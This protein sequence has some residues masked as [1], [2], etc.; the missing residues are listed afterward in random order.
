MFYSG[1]SEPAY[2][3]NKDGYVSVLEA[4]IA[5]A[6][7]TTKLSPQQHPVIADP[8]QSTWIRDLIL[9]NDLRPFN[10]IQVVETNAP[11]NSGSVSVD[12]QD[13]SKPFYFTQD[14]LKNGSD[15]QPAFVQP[16]GNG[17]GT[18]RF[19]DYPTR[20]P[21]VGQEVRWKATL[22]P[23]KWNGAKDVD[24]FS[25]Y[26]MVW[27]FSISPLPDNLGEEWQPDYEAEYDR[28]LIPL[29]SS[30]TPEDKYG[31]AGYDSPETPEGSEAR[32]VPAGNLMDYCVE[33]WNKEDALVPTQDAVILDRLDP[34]TFDISSFE[35]TRYGFLNWDEQPLPGTQVINS[36][37]DLRPDVNLAVEIRAGLGMQVPGFAHNDDIEENTLVWWFHAIDP[38]TGEWPEDPMA[39]FL[40]PFNPETGYEIGWVEFSVQPRSGLPSGTE[41]ANVAYVEFDFAGDIYNHPAPKVDPN[42]E[43]AVPAPW[44]NTIDAGTPTSSVEIL[45]DQSYPGF[46]VRWSGEDDA[47]GSGIDRYNIYV[48]QDGGPFTAWLTRTE[49]TEAMYDV[50]EPD[51]T[52]AFYSIAVDGVGYIE[53]VPVTADTQTTVIELPS[54]LVVGINIENQPTAKIDVEFESSMAIA[55]MIAEGSILSAVLLGSVSGGAISLTAEQFSY[56]DA[57][58]ILSLSL[59]Q[60][61]PE[62]F[63]E[64][65]LDGSKLTSSDGAVLRGGQSGLVF[66]MAS[67]AA[68]QKVQ[69]GGSDLTVNAYSAPSLTDWNSDGRVDLVVGE[70]T[71]ESTGKIR[72]YLNQGTNAS[73]VF[74]TFTYAQITSGDLTV[75]A[76]GCLGVFPRVYDWNGDGKKDLVLGLADGQVQVALN[77]NTDSEPR[78]GLP[79]FVQIAETGAESDLD[80]GD[81]ATI[82]IVDWNND[83]R[84]DLLVGG[85]D[86]R[87]RLYLNEATAG[88]PVFRI[89]TLIQDGTGDLIVSSGR[90]SVAVA[91]LNG[92]GRKDLIV[93]DTSGRLRFYPNM[94]VDSGP[95][96]NGWQ[97]IKADGVEIDL[98]G[99]PRSR[100]FVGDFNNDGILDLVV[101][102]EDGLVRLYLGLTP[103]GPTEL[104]DPLVGLV[105]SPY[106]HTF[107]VTDY[108]N[109]APVLDP[110]GNK[111]VDEL[112]ELTF[113]ATASDQDLPAQTLTFSLVDAPDGA[114]I[115]AN[116]GEF[117]WTPTETQ[118]GTYTFTVLVS[119]GLLTDSEEITVTVAEVNIAPVFDTIGNKEIDELAELAF[120][121]V[122][123][124]DDLPAQPLEF[125]LVDAPDG[126]TINATT[127]EFAWTPT[128]AQDGTHTFTVVVSDGLLTDSK[129]ITV[130]VAEVNVAPVFDTIGNKEINELNELAFTVVAVDEDLPAQTLQFSLVDAPDGATINATTGEF[131]WTPLESQDGT[132]TFTVVVSDGLLTDTEEITVTVAEVNVAPVLDTIGNKEIDE[133]N[134]LTFTIVA[135]DED[136][137]AQTLEYSLVD[138]PD[139]ATINVATGEFAWTPTE[140]QNGTYTFTVVVSDGLLT[141]SEE[142]TVTVAEVNDGPIDLGTVDFWQV[143]G[144]SLANG[145]LYYQLQTAHTGFLTLEVLAPNPPTSARIKLYDQDPVANPGL[146]A[147]VTSTLVGLNQRADL[148]VGS[149]ETYFVEIYGANPD[150]DLRIANLV[151]HDGTTVTVFG[152]DGNDQFVF[153]AS[154]SRM[155]SIKGVAYEFADTEVRLIQFDGGLGYDRVEMRDSAGDET[156]EAWATQATFSNSPDD[157]VADFT[158]NVS[159]F[160]EMHVYADSGGQD[161]AVLY[162][163]AGNDKFKAEPAESYAKMYG[164][165]MYN[166]VKFFDQVDAYGSGGKDLGRVFDSR[167]DETFEGAMGLSR[168]AGDG[169]E[170]DMHDFPRVI[171]CATAGGNDTATLVDSARKDEFHGKAHKSEIFDLVT[172]GDIYRI[173]ARGFDVVQAHATDRT[174]EAGGN[175][176]AKLWGT[177]LDDYIQ[178]AEDWLSYGIR[179]PEL[180]PLYEILAFESV[181]I[182]QTQGGNDRADVADNLLFQLAFDDGWEML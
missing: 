93:G 33:F 168:F 176:V 100:S 57:T 3:F 121:V 15:G 138:A 38:E 48:S 7:V 73:P 66:E 31:P 181:M 137:P 157:S 2:D 39:G 54:V 177:A 94:R 1:L 64:L 165:A 80:V 17:G 158:V 182:R 108:V 134:E 53:D 105:G 167:G 72:V 110:I 89:E 106:V 130:T 147:L 95:V 172:G 56:D 96:F 159:N 46:L 36:R 179:R 174:G 65:R 27:E 166:R 18:L 52:Y 102:A 171:A 40:P 114:T 164:G 71:A 126:A 22:L 67:F 58:H 113:T 152:T 169:F 178:A 98:P 47:G 24:L 10:W 69:A 175:D 11:L 62:D 16:D 79:E 163:S 154:E 86:G 19:L 146:T 12:P 35:F 160:E 140:A 5:A 34:N 60:P 103:G 124:D 104:T 44:I 136:L 112:I 139:G 32:F 148:V 109:V 63:Y 49:L 50:A 20:G 81:R 155:V 123:I 43:P 26:A 29:R 51:H 149:G 91:D 125:S 143:D 87:V 132:Y 133:L 45:P 150:F 30:Y 117:T 153:N 118:D 119:D 75:P 142:I 70:K 107:A 151:Q 74:D 68:A 14:A 115:N 131:T 156:L 41:L 28:K 128:E 135:I 13:P 77:E 120:T 99:T 116:T 42:A 21:R 61:L 8:S 92:D 88:V 127:G 97:T 111:L 161:V 83:G 90:A 25:Q 9:L 129:E 37:I 4:S 85:L 122:A 162:G 82:E 170:I 59:E 145:S 76:S 84:A 180:D 101:G 78:F 23:S 6:E 144:L 141:D 173:T 55:S